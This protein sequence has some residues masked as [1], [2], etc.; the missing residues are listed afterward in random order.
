MNDKTI[1]NNFPTANLLFVLCLRVNYIHK[2][3]LFPPEFKLLLCHLQN[4]SE[5]KNTNWKVDVDFNKLCG[6]ISMKSMEPKLIS[7]PL[8]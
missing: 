6:F 3:P 8:I 2:V 7:E 4:L 1:V 5:T